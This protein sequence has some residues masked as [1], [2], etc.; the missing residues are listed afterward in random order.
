EIGT[1]RVFRRV[2]QV[3]ERAVLPRRRVDGAE[4][5]GERKMLLVAEVLVTEEQDTPLHERLVNR[6]E[7]VVVERLAEVDAVH[8][9]PGVGGER[10]ELDSRHAPQPTPGPGPE[11]F[12]VR[13]SNRDREED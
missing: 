11:A 12:G 8:D 9:R 13:C 3:L 7:D 10:L 2:L 1:R 6:R 5:A 4:A